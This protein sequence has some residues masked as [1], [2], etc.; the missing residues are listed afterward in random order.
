MTLARSRTRSRW[1]ASNGSVVTSALVASRTW[2]SVIN[3]FFPPKPLGLAGHEEMTHHADVPVA[4]DG[5]IFADLEMREAQLAFLVLQDAFDG[6]TCKSDMQ[7]G[8][9]LVFERIPD[10]EPLFLF[11]VQRIVS[12]D[13][14]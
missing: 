14:V 10:E 1:S 13:E 7:P 3:G 6:P 12:P 11:R 8:F 9:E 4:Q 5:L 2:L